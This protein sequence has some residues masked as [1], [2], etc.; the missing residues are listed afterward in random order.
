MIDTILVFWLL[1]SCIAVLISG[2]IDETSSEDFTKGQVFLLC[3][4]VMVVIPIM[5]FIYEGLKYAVNYRSIKKEKELKR[6][7]NINNY[8]ETKRK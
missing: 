6:I 2:L 7:E 8:I 1:W 4:S 5:V 3:S